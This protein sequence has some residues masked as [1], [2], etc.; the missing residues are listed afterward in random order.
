MKWIWCTYMTLS[1]TTSYLKIKKEIN[2]VELHTLTHSKIVARC[3]CTA[4]ASTVIAFIS[5]FNA[6]YLKQM[7]GLVLFLEKKKQNKTNQVYWSEIN[8]QYNCWMNYYYADETMWSCNRARV[9]FYIQRSNN[10]LTLCVCIIELFSSY[11]LHF[12][13]KGIYKK[14]V[15]LSLN[16]LKYKTRG[17]NSFTSI[18]QNPK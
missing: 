10:K 9:W 3:L 8:N 14:S 13:I 11:L 5:M 4:W 16:F 2:V 17:L 1:T 12:T 7:L 18:Y 6:T 15:N